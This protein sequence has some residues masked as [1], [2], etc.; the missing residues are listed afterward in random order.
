M[1]LTIQPQGKKNKWLVY[2]TLRYYW[3]PSF[4]T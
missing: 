4:S 2:K 1:K 3:P